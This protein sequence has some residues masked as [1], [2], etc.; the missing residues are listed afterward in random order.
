MFTSFQ[1]EPSHQN[2]QTRANRNYLASNQKTE[3]CKPASQ[4]A[5]EQAIRATSSRENLSNI[6]ESDIGSKKKFNISRRDLKELIFIDR[7]AFATD[8]NTKAIKVNSPNDKSVT[9]KREA[10]RSAL[11]HTSNMQMSKSKGLDIRSSATYG[12]RKG[13]Q[14]EVKSPRSPKDSRNMKESTV[15]KTEPSIA[16]HTS[17]QHVT[18]TY[19]KN[20]NIDNKELANLMK[21]KH[22]KRVKSKAK[23]EMGREDL[24]PEKC[25]KA[26]GEH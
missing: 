12:N 2:L 18:D 23:K 24:S 13:N 8:I 9:V 26:R 4:I 19:I 5:R 20:K 17:S 25:N 15:K 11:E 22:K 14:I 3:G 10:Q 16:I 6:K 1:K 21:F 7:K